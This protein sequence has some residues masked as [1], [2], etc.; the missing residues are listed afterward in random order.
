MVRSREEAVQAE[1]ERSSCHVKSRREGGPVDRGVAQAARRGLEEQ[2]KTQA[3]RIAELERELREA[4]DRVRDIAL[5]PS[6]A[7]AAPPVLQRV[8][9]LALHQARPRRRE[10]IAARPLAFSTADC[11]QNGLEI[12]G[13]SQCFCLAEAGNLQSCDSTKRSPDHLVILVL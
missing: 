8:S 2:T 4:V 13:F 3:T 11:W 12:I 7:L 1:R 10:C 5:K 9:E 6:R